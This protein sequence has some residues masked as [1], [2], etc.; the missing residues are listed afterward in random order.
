MTNEV[1]NF[2]D[3]CWIFY[4]KDEAGNPGMYAHLFDF[5]LDKEK[6]RTCISRL[7]NQGR[8][9][10][11]DSFDRELVRDVLLATF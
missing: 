7:V 5:S 6:L 8:I 2:T 4:G 11:F 10:N 1:D 9:Q 3:Y